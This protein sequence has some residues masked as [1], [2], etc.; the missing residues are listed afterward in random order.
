[1]IRVSFRHHSMLLRNSVLLL[2]ADTLFCSLLSLFSF[3]PSSPS[4]LAPHILL[5]APEGATHHFNSEVN[6]FEAACRPS[7][8][9]GPPRKLPVG[10]WSFTAL[11]A[12]S[13]STTE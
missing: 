11:C 10:C 2:A 12:V 4:H 8:A 1:M 5:S 6:S 7:S 3:L 13:P 9:S